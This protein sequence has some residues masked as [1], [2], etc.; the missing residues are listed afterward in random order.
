MGVGDAPR[1]MSR[2]VISA[3]DGTGGSACM[4]ST[5]ETSLARHSPGQ[6]ASSCC[7]PTP[8]GFATAPGC[9]SMLHGT[10]SASTSPLFS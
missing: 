1:E 7:Q 10:S 6:V 2:V 4:P 9:I 8:S 3:S 5:P